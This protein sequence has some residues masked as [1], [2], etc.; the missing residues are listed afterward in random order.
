[1]AKRSERT[2][3]TYD[4]KTNTTTHRERIVETH[5]SL[6]ATAL[7]GVFGFVA[8]VWAIKKNNE[9]K[10]LTDQDN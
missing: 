7:A 1:M 5:T 4:P 2:Q 6:T 3:H 10:D 8:G 9:Q